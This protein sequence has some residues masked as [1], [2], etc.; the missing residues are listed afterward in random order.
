MKMMEKDYLWITTDPVTSLVQSFNASTV[1][2]MPGIIG[3]K[4]Y[5]PESGNQFILI[6]G[7]EEGLAQKILK[8]V[9]LSLKC[10]QHKLMRLQGKWL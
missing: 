4:C 6:I 3:V 1:S 8:M 5:F 9:T 7:F 10:L 2:S